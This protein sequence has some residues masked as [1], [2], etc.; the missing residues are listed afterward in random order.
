MNEGW[1]FD[2]L[3]TF[4]MKEDNSMEEEEVYLMV[5]Y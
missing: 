3:L 5:E 4:Y 2:K 1:T